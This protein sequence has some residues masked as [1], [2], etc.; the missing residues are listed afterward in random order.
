M[1]AIEEENQGEEGEEEG[2]NQQPQQQQE[3]SASETVQ[4]GEKNINHLN[5]SFVRFFPADINRSTSRLDDLKLPSLNDLTGGRRQ[6]F[7]G[8]SCT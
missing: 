1:Q 3:N 2:P 8:I 5:I 7:H 4:R 6:H